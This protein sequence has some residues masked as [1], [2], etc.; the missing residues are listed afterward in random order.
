MKKI[1]YYVVCIIYSTQVLFNLLCSRITTETQNQG[2]YRISLYN[3]Y[4][5]AI[6][7]PVVGF[8]EYIMPKWQRVDI[9]ERDSDDWIF[10]GFKVSITEEYGFVQ[11]SDLSIEETSEGFSLIDKHQSNKTLLYVHKAP[12]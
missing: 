9:V 12:L 8:V 2:R 5:M 7:I 3:E 11:I 10:N 4:S 1:I 6:Y